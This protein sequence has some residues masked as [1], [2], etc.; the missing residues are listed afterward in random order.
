MRSMD[1]LE[2]NERIRQKRKE[3]LERRKTQEAKTYELK[4]IG[5]R[6]LRAGSHSCRASFSRQSGSLTI[7]Q[8]GI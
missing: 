3:V 5:A 6:S 7:S 8:R 4:V 1:D 2:E